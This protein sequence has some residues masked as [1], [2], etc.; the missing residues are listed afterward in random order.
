MIA[1]GFCP[2][3]WPYIAPG[4]PIYITEG[5]FRGLTGTMVAATS[6]RWL[7]VSVHLLQRSVAVKLD[8][9]SLSS[10]AISQFSFSERTR[11]VKQ[12]R[13]TSQSS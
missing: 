4:E 5:P 8:R 12:A 6:E 2:R 9:A 11:A 7:V 13:G 3:P 1:G 10:R